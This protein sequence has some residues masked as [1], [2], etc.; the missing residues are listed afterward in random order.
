MLKKFI[1]NYNGHQGIDGKRGTRDNGMGVQTIVEI[2]ADESASH[3]LAW[4]TI[5]SANAGSELDMV[6]RVGHQQAG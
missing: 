2:C 3:V 1:L 5:A 4:A 6:G